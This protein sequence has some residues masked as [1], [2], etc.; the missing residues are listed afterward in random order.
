MHNQLHE[1][2]CFNLSSQSSEAVILTKGLSSH[3]AS[4]SEIQIVLSLICEGLHLPLI[5]ASLFQEMSIVFLNNLAEYVFST[6]PNGWL[7]C[8]SCQCEFA[9]GLYWYRM[10]LDAT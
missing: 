5:A 2:I 6:L 7:V 9:T 1:S 8:T 4:A 10:S 3:G